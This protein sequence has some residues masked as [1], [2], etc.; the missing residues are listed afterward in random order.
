MNMR[1]KM[2]QAMTKEMVP[3]LDSDVIY[4][5]DPVIDAI[6]DVLR[7]MPETTLVYRSTDPVSVKGL[8]V[9]TVNAIKAGK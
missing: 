3:Y 8:W 4:S 2:A 1:E 5:D 6:L 7:D 9:G